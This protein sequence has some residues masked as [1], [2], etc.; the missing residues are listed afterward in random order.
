LIDPFEISRVQVWL[1]EAGEIALRYYQ[2]Q[3]AKRQKDDHSPVTEADEV[4]EKFIIDKI[5]RESNTRDASILA[6]ESGG[7]GADK[8]FVWAL[9]PIDGTR[10][11]LNGLPLW[12]ISLG[13]LQNGEAYRGAVYLPATKNLYYTDNAGNAFWNNRSLAG[14]LPDSWDQDS[15]IAVPSGAH[16]YFEID[17]RRLR[18][19]GAIATHHVFVASGVAVAAL[20][21]QVGLWDIAGAQAILKAVGGTAV[22]LDG[23]PLLLTELLTQGK[24]ACQRP[25]LAGH[26]GLIDEILPRIRPIE[27]TAADRW[28]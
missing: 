2:T 10:V 1:K 16:R 18:A 22:H 5:R 8:E 23:T 20:H 19:L 9:D 25:V 15:F 21:R 3:L 13:L 14:M 7:S 26:P 24:T 17:F 27:Q 4:V 11:F 28:A 12:C 6:E